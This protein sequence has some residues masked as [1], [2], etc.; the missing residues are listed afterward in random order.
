[1]SNLRIVTDSTADLPDSIRRELGIEM[2]PLNVHFGPE[3]F[4]DVVEMSSEQFWAKLQTSPHHPKTSQ[5]SPGDFLEVY[6]RVA[7]SGATEIVS[8]HIS[9]ALSGTIGSAQIAAEMV[10]DKH[11]VS[12]SIVD[13]KS[14]T[15]GVGLIAIEAAR[16]VQAGKSRD[17]VVQWANGAVSRMHVLFTLDT[18]DFLQ[19]NGRIGKAAALL[20][21]LLNFKPILQIDREGVVDRVD[22]V[23]GKSKVLPR[24][25]ELMAERVAPG[26]TIRCA[27]MHANA[28]EEATQW[29]QEIKQ[30]Y[31][32]TEAHVSEI[33]PVIATN[34]GPGTIGVAFHEV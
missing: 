8:I 27:F 3:T 9:G 19:K 32:V 15:Y 31:N 13:T 30:I 14:V 23:R 20:G 12:I 33:G 28:G 29:L 11:Q 2:V 5:P 21:G 22:R 17:E 4:R 18:L 25:K 26:R 1:M 16:M 10:Q 7:A 24:L 6:E 34:G